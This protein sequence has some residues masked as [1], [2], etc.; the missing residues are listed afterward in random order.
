MP[1][2]RFG[3]ERKL[4]AFC[5]RHYG[6][7][8]MENIFNC[9]M[10]IK[11]PVPIMGIRAAVNQGTIVSRSQ[12]E[13]DIALSMIRRKS[14]FERVKN[15]R[16]TG[17]ASLSDLISEATAGGKR[18]Q[19]RYAKTSTITAAA[20][21]DNQDL[22]NVGA[23]PVAGAV[24]AAA[25]GGTSYDNTTQ[26]GLQQKNPGGADTLH[27]TTWLGQATVA[28][29]ILL[30]D[31][32][33]AWLV[34][35]GTASNAITGTQ[36]RYNGA[37]GTLSYPASSFVSSRITTVR[38]ANAN[39]VAFTYKDQDNSA[40][41]ANTA[42]AMISSGAVGRPCTGGPQGTWAL[43]LNTTDTGIYEVTNITYSGTS[44]GVSEFVHGYPLAI[45]PCIVANIGFVLDGINSA[46]NL[47]QIQASACLAFFE[48][49]KT[50]TA[51][52][53]YSGLIT[54]VSG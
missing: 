37:A 26:G 14:F 18:Q 24:A 51:V 2:L 5:E 45:L 30:Y 6:P 46:F 47:V 31:R 20:V 53:T 7:E 19:L 1:T 33:R 54:L 15:E 38:A 39:T 9:S 17:F 50:T 42:A 40:A 23:N 27:L 52:D 21:G 16:G 4:E 25:A 8:V 34:S 49:S 43:A 10:G 48:F 32:L 29:N 44:T 36:T 41:E 13:R 3:P 22:W 12:Q 28:S 35:E 11:G